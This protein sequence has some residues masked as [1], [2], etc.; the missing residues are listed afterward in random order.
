MD[1]LPVG[2]HSSIKP[3]GPFRRVHERFMRNRVGILPRVSKTLFPFIPPKMPPSWHLPNP[4]NLGILGIR[5]TAWVNGWG[6]RGHAR[7]IPWFTPDM[8]P[9]RSPGGRS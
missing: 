7:E 2:S 9:H 5:Q 3:E 8:P 6:W 4:E 1:G